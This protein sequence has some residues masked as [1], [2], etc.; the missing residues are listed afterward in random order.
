MKLIPPD[1]ERC[2]VEEL[3]GS[4]MTLG[5]RSYVR[6]EEKPIL[7]ISEVKPGE[8]GKKGEM[9]MCAAHYE[10]FKEFKPMK[11]KTKLIQEKK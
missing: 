6:C 4:F 7:I 5:P 8:D 3:E 11:H 1:K 2:Q 9:S 10:K